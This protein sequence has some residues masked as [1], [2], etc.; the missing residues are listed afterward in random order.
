MDQARKPTTGEPLCRIDE[1]GEEGREAIAAGAD[2]EP[3]YVAL[4]RRG[5]R[6]LAYHNVC[7]HAGRALNWAPDRFLFTPAGHLVCTAHGATF[8]LESGM[9]I[10]GP[11][12]GA[13]LEP[14]PIR[15]ADGKVYAAAGD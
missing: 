12:M 1:I 4:F 9:C 15:I 8:V 6:V 5:G 7:P 11:C 13:S 14:F 3:T 10:L 2:G